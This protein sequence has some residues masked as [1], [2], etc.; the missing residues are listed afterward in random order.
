MGLNIHRSLP[1]ES[2]QNEGTRRPTSRGGAGRRARA[3]ARARASRSPGAPAACPLSS[4]HPAPA[5]SRAW[6]ATACLD[7]WVVP[8]LVSD[9][10]E[11]MPR[12]VASR[13]DH[14]QFGG[15]SRKLSSRSFSSHSQLRQHRL[16]HRPRSDPQLRR[17]HTPW[18]RRTGHQFQLCFRGA[19]AFH[20]LARRTSE[21]ARIARLRV[22]CPQPAAQLRPDEARSPA[23]EATT[24]AVPVAGVPSF[25]EIPPAPTS[26]GRPPLQLHRAAPKQGASRERR[27]GTAALQAQDLPTPGIP[28]D[29][30]DGLVMQKGLGWNPPTTTR[31]TARAKAAA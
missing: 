19:A 16:L 26:R 25:D 10:R 23:D 29:A 17:Q 1:P 15:L 6:P 11:S 18:L 28:H 21:T 12:G 22:R 24:F 9:F 5:T 2:L 20:P 4:Q 27:P 14:L 13:V 31:S 30:A 8:L 3:R 7:R